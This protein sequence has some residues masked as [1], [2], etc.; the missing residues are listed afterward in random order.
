MR[1]GIQENNLETGAEVE[2]R[3]EC[4]FLVHNDAL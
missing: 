2:A 1:I 4:C 3:E